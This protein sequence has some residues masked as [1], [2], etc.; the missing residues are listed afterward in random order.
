MSSANNSHPDQEQQIGNSRDIFYG[1]IFNTT[2]HLGPKSLA[3]VL[4]LNRRANDFSQ[5]EL[6]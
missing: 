4:D 1:A 6:V 2:Y 3:F 5:T